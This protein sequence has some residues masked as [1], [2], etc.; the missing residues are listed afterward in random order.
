[1]QT[2]TV[3]HKSLAKE[4][5]SSCEVMSNSLNAEDDRCQQQQMQIHESRR[6]SV[7][8]PS[9]Q[10]PELDGTAM[11]STGRV[12]DSAAASNAMPSALR[13]LSQALR[14]SPPSS[15]WGSGFCGL[16][17]P[18]WAALDCACLSMTCHHAITAMHDLY[19][20]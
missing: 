20:Y 17:S 4:W 18:V 7:A 5:S 14:A 11:V 6:P 1:M 10:C 16:L 12:P 13:P 2:A 15:V 8:H 3:P 19:S 9:M